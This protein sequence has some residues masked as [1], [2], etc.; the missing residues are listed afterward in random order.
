MYGI[1]DHMTNTRTEAFPGLKQ[2]KFLYGRCRMIGGGGLTFRRILSIG[3]LV[4]CVACAAGA[5]CAGDA[6]ALADEIQSR[7]VRGADS[8]LAARDKAQAGA[9]KLESFLPLVRTASWTERWPDA[10]GKPTACAVTGE[11]W[12]AAIQAALDKQGTVT[13]PARGQPYYLDAP[14][15]LKSGQSLTAEARAELRLQPGVNT[16]MVRN[17]RVVGAQTGPAPED[18]A[19]DSDI[20]IEGGIWTT[21]GTGSGEWNGNTRGRSARQNDVPGCHGV[22]LL[23]NVRG[24]VVRNVTIRRSCAFGVHVINSRDFLVENVTFDENGR[25]GVHVNG[26]SSYGV[27]RGVRGVTHDDFVAL[28]AWEWANYAPSFG[29]IHHMLVEDVVGADRASADA[30]S[31]FPDGTAEIRLLPGTK[32][33]ADGSK[34]ACEIAACVFRRLENIR[35][36]KAYD[37]PNLELGRDKDFCD[38]IGTLRDIHFAQLVFTR[39][40]C[41]QIAAHVEGFD[42]DGVQLRFQPSEAFKLVEIGPMSSTYKLE[43]NDPAKWVELFSPDKD[44][45]VHAFRLANVSAVKD[46]QTVPLADAA[47][48]LVKIADQKPN[49]DYPKTLPRGGKGRTIVK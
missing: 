12:T 8:A 4:A 23:N 36:V 17:E 25:D 21:L 6:G 7:V 2:S 47:A 16:C 34:L 19:F 18:A 22:I 11:I 10:Q 13:I 15:V 30:A 9:Q 35:T 43:P 49:P 33:F 39:P 32:T 1:L 46:G 48:R 26:P 45:T 28:N 3:A 24:A 44:V 38:P 41:F 29:P 42:I 31:P 40:G 5:A 20:V 14:L 27:V 37:Q